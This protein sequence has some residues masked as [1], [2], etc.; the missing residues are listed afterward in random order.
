MQS[1]ARPSNH[2]IYH[3]EEKRCTSCSAPARVLAAFASGCI[4][5]ENCMS[6]P[7][8]DPA[9]IGVA[10][11]LVT[12]FA[13]V[14]CVDVAVDEA[15][16]NRRLAGVSEPGCPAACQPC[17]TCQSHALVPLSSNAC[18]PSAP[19]PISRSK[20]HRHDPILDTWCVQGGLAVSPRA[21][22]NMS[23]RMIPHVYQA[24]GFFTHS[25]YDSNIRIG[26]FIGHRAASQSVAGTWSS[27]QGIW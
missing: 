27:P 26:V 24:A 22:A 7:A 18:I 21:V 19:N 17:K 15:A 23:R 12:G 14:D 10:A 3:E 4:D 25:A 6:E 2:T 1:K 8:S 16:S 13:C 20:S 11:V 9:W 5:M